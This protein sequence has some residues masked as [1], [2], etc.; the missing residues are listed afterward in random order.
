[1]LN[2]KTEVAADDPRPTIAAADLA[3]FRRIAAE[4]A[5]LAIGDDK[6]DFLVAR[7]GGQ[8]ARLGLPDFAAYARHL[9][10]AVDPRER[11]SFV[12]ALT[13]HTTGFFRER[14]QYDWLE[15]EGFDT[16]AR[17]GA[18]RD[19]TLVIWSAACSS[20]QEL[21]SALMLAHARL[22]TGR[23]S[24]VA[25]IGTDLSRSILR[26][27]RLGIYSG[28]EIEGIPLELRRR[29]LL[30]A[31][32]GPERFRIAP[33]LRSR[34]RWALA[35]L[36]LPA[37]L[38]GIGADL[39]FLRNVLI[40][41]DA[42]TRTRVLKAVIARLRRGGVLLTGHSETVD[43]RAFGLAAIRPSIYRKEEG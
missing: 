26:R 6:T 32:T 40:Y 15:A 36:T 18:G 1:M 3:L 19:R 33:E 25:G 30:S 4:E 38:G 41:F 2:G 9:A 42:P 10:R 37:E 29:Y 27:G 35:N 28:E 16:L 20:G 34:C 21:Y 39:V 13:T 12:E 43:A 17:I 31:R 23:L 24:A 7:L 5:G 14:S 8:L 22:A 11:R